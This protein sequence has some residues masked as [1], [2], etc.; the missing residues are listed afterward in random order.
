MARVARRHPGGGD[1]GPHGGGHGEADPRRR[2]RAHQRRQPRAGRLQPVR[3]ATGRDRERARHRFLRPGPVLRVR[4]ARHPGGHRRVG[5]PH[6]GGLHAGRRQRLGA[7]GRTLG[8][9]HALRDQEPQ[10][11]AL[12]R[13]GRRLRGG[14]TDLAARVGRPGRPGDPP[15]GRVGW[16]DRVHAFQGGGQRLP[17]LPR[18]RPGAPGAGRRLARAGPPR[19]RGHAGRPPGRAGRGARGRAERGRGRPDPRRGGSRA[20]RPGDRGRGGRGA[21]GAGAGPDGQRG[22]GPGRGGHRADGRVVRR[23][24]DHGG[25]GRA[26]G[27]AIQDRAGRPDRAGRRSRRA[28]QGV[29]L[30]GAG[31]GHPLGR[32]RRGHRR[33]P[34]RVGALR[35]R[36]GQNDRRPHRCRHEGDVGQGQRQGGGGRA[37]PP[38]RASPP[39]RRGNCPTSARPTGRSRPARRSRSVACAGCSG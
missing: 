18:A 20:R 7:P 2:E 8:L 15:L 29:G 31:V 39:G 33:Q 38:P 12:A 5:R 36:G 17:L 6:G 13:T 25:G 10:L 14:A 3:G 11:V 1:P 19:P 23:V 28:G 26:L 32:P 37:A 16:P 35:G 9:R 21:D 27:H 24:V 4:A 30:R 22:G 34:G